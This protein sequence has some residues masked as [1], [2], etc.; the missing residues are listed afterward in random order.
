MRNSFC[1]LDKRKNPS[2]KSQIPNPKQIQKGRK[3]K[4]QNGPSP[5]WAFWIF[6][7]FGHLDFFG[8]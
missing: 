4:I 7:S 3:S 5:V 8:I 2:T 1:Q 6:F